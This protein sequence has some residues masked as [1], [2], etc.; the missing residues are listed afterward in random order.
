MAPNVNDETV[1]DS[2]GFELLS[3]TLNDNNNNIDPDV[4]SELCVYAT[5]LQKEKKKLSNVEKN[6]LDDFI[7]NLAA[8]R[9]SEENLVKSQIEQLRI[10]NDRKEQVIN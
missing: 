7:S 4:F 3:K 9:L 2:I 5:T 10:E 1:E 6:W 8:A